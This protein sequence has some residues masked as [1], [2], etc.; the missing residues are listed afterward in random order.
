MKLLLTGAR[1]FVGRHV[2]EA[3]VSAHHVRAL[4]RTEDPVFI[5]RFG[6]VEQALGDLRDAAA[7][8][9]AL[10]GCDAVVH[11]A[12]SIEADIEACNVG[13]TRHLCERLEGRP[14]VYLSSTGVY[15][16]GEQRRADEDT[17]IAP[18]TPL[19][20]SRA[21]AERMVLDAGGLVLRPRFVYGRGD[22][23]VIPRL[24]RVVRKLPLLVDGGRAELSFV[25]APDLA[26]VVALLL[27][28]EG[29]LEGGALHVTD[30]RPLPL[31]ELVEILCAKLGRTAPRLSVPMGLLYW[32]LRA[33]EVLLR[34]DPESTGSTFSSLRLEM[35]T[36]HNSFADARLMQRL[37]GLE[38]SSF[39]EGLARSWPW[40][41][42]LTSGGG[43]GT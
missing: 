26:R 11:L 21:Q 3:L 1:G 27:G 9:R 12:T 18:D 36:R 31:R 19:S 41:E 25:Y 23:A 22:R 13:G 5:Q 6:G 32:P 40:Y 37:P 4:L 15:G 28:A 43:Q 33:K 14:I 10:R 34:S 38:R 30:G 35:M 8:E 2:T 16:H 20:R 39:A 42:S 29:Q 24:I 17:P 7:V